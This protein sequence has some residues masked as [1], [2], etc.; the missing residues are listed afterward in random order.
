MKPHDNTETCYAPN[1]QTK[2]TAWFSPGWTILN[3]SST[4]AFIELNMRRR[5]DTQKTRNNSIKCNNNKNDWNTNIS[6]SSRCEPKNVKYYDVL[7]VWVR[8]EGR[9]IP[10]D[11]RWI[12]FGVRQRKIENIRLICSIYTMLTKSNNK[13]HWK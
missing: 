5:I 1:W 7:K 9:P 4:L 6:L 12:N 11:K 2:W 3:V 8:R 13:Q 10:K